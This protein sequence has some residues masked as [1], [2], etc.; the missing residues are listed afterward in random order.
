MKKIIALQNLDC[1]NCASKMETKISKIKGVFSVSV[2]FLTQK[3][4]LDI[5]E[6]AF[7]SIVDEIKAVCKKVEPDCTLKI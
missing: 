1:A 3:M 5:E 7:E 4:I 6:T 2:N